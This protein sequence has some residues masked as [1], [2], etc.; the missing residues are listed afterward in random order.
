MS[1]VPVA[2]ALSALVSVLTA[3]GMSRRRAIAAASDA[4]RAVGP[5]GL[6]DHV[7]SLASLTPRK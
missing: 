2:L 1:N 4:L 3:H 6:A 7:A 5:E